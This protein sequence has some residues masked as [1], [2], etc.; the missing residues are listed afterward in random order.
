[1]GKNYVRGEIVLKSYRFCSEFDFTVGLLW[2]TK[3]H[4]SGWYNLDIFQT[5]CLIIRKGF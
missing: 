3:K 2:F 5:Y 4:Y 1:M